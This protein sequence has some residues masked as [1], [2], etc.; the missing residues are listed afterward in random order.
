MFALRGSVPHA[1]GDRA[2]IWAHPAGLLK[3]LIRNNIERRKGGRRP[4]HPKFCRTG[5]PFAQMTHSLQDALDE[6]LG[7]IGR[8][9][10]RI[11]VGEGAERAAQRPRLPGE[12]PRVRGT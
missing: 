8:A 1:S 12:R 11:R 4:R 10:D 3:I 6:T 7:F 5:S 2:A 9:L